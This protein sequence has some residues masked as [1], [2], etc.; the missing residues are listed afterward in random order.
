MIPVSTPISTSRI[1]AYRDKA[2]PRIHVAAFLGQ[3]DTLA[4]GRPGRP[5]RKPLLSPAALFL[6]R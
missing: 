4:S 1:A 2:P 6:E 5:C 3:S